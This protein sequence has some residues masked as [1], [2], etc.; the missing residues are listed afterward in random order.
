MNIVHGTGHIHI[1]HIYS[2]S[3]ISSGVWH[4]SFE[5]K[6]QNQNRSSCF[7]LIHTQHIIAQIG[8]QIEIEWID[9]DLTSQPIFQ[10]VRFC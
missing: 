10:I 4:T 8:K 6:Y 3:H 9:D 7:H 1:L 5:Q 2:K